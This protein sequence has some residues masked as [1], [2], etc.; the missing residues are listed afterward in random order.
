M[1][2]VKAISRCFKILKD[3]GFIEYEYES[4]KSNV[5]TIKPMQSVTGLQNKAM[6]S[7][8]RT[9]KLNEPNRINEFNGSRGAKE[10]YKENL[11]KDLFL[12]F[13]K[14]Y[15][16]EKFDDDA[17]FDAWQSLTDAD[18]QL[19]LGVM[20]Y[21]NNQWDNPNFDRTFIYLASNYLLKKLYLKKNVKKHYDDKLGRKKE[22]VERREYLKEADKHSASDDEKKE[23]LSNW[24]NQ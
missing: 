10:N 21:Q 5:I 18:K 1:S 14:K 15:P 11:K 19:V 2:G 20:E 23:I 16:A 7:V 13:K 6:K 8:N 22:A 3:K 9:D 4:G 24:K 12:E 17:A